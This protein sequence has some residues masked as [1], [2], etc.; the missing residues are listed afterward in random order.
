ML[1]SKSF[2][3]PG[4]EYKTISEYGISQYQPDV[5]ERMLDQ[6]NG[7]ENREQLLD[8]MLQ[9]LALDIFMGQTD[10]YAFNY[11]FEEDKHHNIRLAPLFDFEYSLRPHFVN[12]NDVCYGDLAQLRSI[13]NCKEFIKRYP[14]FRDLLASYL[15]ESLISNVRCAYAKRGMQVSDKHIEAF[16]DFEKKQKAK[17]K[18]IVL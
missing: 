8:D 18:K 1:G 7:E 3:R 6:A 10:R 11:E 15:D 4:F 9:M 12:E 2:Y 5:L 13:E 17:I 14:E 16:Q